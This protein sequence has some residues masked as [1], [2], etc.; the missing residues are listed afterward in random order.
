MATLSSILAWRIPWTEEPGRWHPGYLHG[1]HKESATTERLSTAQ[2][3]HQVSLV[4]PLVSLKN[5]G[6]GLIYLML[7]DWHPII[8][9]KSTMTW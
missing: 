1:G 9:S 2:D 8:L 6:A 5:L 3:F 7:I 4:R